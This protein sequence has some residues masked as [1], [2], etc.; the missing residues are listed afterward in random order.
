MTWPHAQRR[1]PRATQ[2]KNSAANTAREVRVQAVR[3]VHEQAV[4][5]DLMPG[6]TVSETSTRS[7]H[8]SSCCALPRSSAADASSSRFDNS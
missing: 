4:V 8:M 6:A 3:I 1:R 5:T 7:S 2:R